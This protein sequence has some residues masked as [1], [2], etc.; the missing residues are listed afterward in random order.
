MVKGAVIYSKPCKPVKIAA[1]RIVT[2]NEIQDW[3]LEP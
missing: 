3:N 2:I 1:K